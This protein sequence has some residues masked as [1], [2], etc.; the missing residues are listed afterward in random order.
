METIAVYW[1]P[2]VRVYGYEIKRN[3]S[4]IELDLPFDKLEAAGERADQLARN[5]KG[6]TMTL[7]QQDSER[8]YRFCIATDNEDADTVVRIFCQIAAASDDVLVREPHKVELLSF[9]GPH[10]QDRYGIAEATFSTLAQ[11]DILIYAASCTGT[12]VY[13][14]VEEGKA[15]E[16][17]NILSASFVVPEPKARKDLL[18]N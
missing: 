13:L 4:L 17:R 10:F 5:N 8:R 2:V 6:F 7:V 3:I 1:E 12:S 15:E 9:H 14:I 11:S 18:R 16:A